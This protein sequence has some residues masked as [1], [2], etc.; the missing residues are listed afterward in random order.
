MNGCAKELQ[1]SAIYSI[2]WST[3][4]FQGDTPLLD[5]D[6]DRSNEHTNEI[7][8]EAQPPQRQVRHVATCGGSHVTVYEVEVP[9]GRTKRTDGLTLRQAYVDPD[10]DEVLYSCVFSKQSLGRPCGYMPVSNGGVPIVLGNEKENHGGK[11]LSGEKRAHNDLSQGSEDSHFTNELG[12][13]IFQ[14]MT[15]MPSFDGPQLLCVAGTR[16]VIKVMIR[17]GRCWP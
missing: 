16:G 6:S 9:F 13:T 12:S 10:K 3:D 14:T 1:G 8:S 2:A 7:L 17:S 15:D 11:P 4:V 5:T